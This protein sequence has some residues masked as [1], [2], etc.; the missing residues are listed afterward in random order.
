MKEMKHQTLR[1]VAYS[2]G[3]LVWLMAIAGVVVS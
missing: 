2:L 1:I 3:V